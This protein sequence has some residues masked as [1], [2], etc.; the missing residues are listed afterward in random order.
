M[1]SSTNILNNVNFEFLSNFFFRIKTFVIMKSNAII[2][3]IINPTH[4]SHSDK[5]S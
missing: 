1:N 5:T 2:T 4:I 3:P